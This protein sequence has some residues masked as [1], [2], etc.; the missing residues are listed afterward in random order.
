MNR[1]EIRNKMKEYGIKHYIVSC[2]HLTEDGRKAWEITEG[3]HKC[4]YTE[5]EFDREIQY[6]EKRGYNFFDVIHV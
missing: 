2:C 3:F 6:L 4:H 5:E 1:I